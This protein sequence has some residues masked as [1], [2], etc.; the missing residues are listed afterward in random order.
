MDLSSSSALFA[1]SK[2]TIIPI[3]LGPS[4]LFFLE[5]AHIQTFIEVSFLTLM[6]Y[7]TCTA[8]FYLPIRIVA[9]IFC[10]DDFGQTGICTFKMH[11]ENITDQELKIRYFWVIFLVCV[12][13]Y[14]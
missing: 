6:T 14:R 2:G 5:T 8:S 1:R 11:S 9:N 13:A 3:D 4:L 12:N 10:S 7:T